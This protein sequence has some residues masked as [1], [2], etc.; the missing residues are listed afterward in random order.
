MN[1]IIGTHNSMS[2]LPVNSWYMRI[3]SIFAK[4]QNLALRKQL[5]RDIQCFD[6]RVYYSK[7]DD[8]WYF[9]HGLINYSTVINLYNALDVIDKYAAYK[10]TSFYIRI[11]LEKGDYN[12][13]FIKLCGCLLNKYKHVKFIGGYKKSN[14]KLLFDFTNNNIPVTQHVGS[15]A[16]D[17]RWYERFIP[18]LY[19]K[20]KNK[21]IQIV[22][23]INLID[24]YE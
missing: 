18:I 10:G 16:K 12:A 4:C 11:I 24:F 23:G 1:W 9:A 5:D 7:K 19:S 3:F 22:E 17:A 8:K 6:L 20:R 15:M 14:W 21:D 13:E 2:Y